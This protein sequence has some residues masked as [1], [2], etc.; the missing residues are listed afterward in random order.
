MRGGLM[1]SHPSA[2]RI[3]DCIGWG[4]IIEP[5]PLDDSGRRVERDNV[6]HCPKKL[7]RSRK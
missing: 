2:D 3:M 5:N 1:M 6:D 4:N 7:L